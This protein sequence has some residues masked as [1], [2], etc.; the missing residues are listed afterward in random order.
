M[1]ERNAADTA[2]R[3]LA[4][5]AAMMA[6]PGIIGLF[7]RIPALIKPNA[8]FAPARPG[9]LVLVLTA[10]CTVLAL[11]A[12][13]FR[14]VRIL[15]VITIFMCGVGLYAN[16]ARIS[17]PL[18]RLMQARVPE[19]GPLRPGFGNALS[20]VALFIAIAVTSI[21]SIATNPSQRRAIVISALSSIICTIAGV[22]TFAELAGLLQAISAREWLQAPLQSLIAAGLLG[23]A[24]FKRVLRGERL[25]IA[26]P[27]WT[28]PVVGLGS[29]IVVVVLWSGLE[30]R[31]RTQLDA[32]ARIASGATHRAIDRQFTWIS[33]AT[34][35]MALFITTATSA[36]DL[37]G[38]S[39]TQLVSET[40]GLARMMLI[41]SAGRIIRST[42]ADSGDAISPQLMAQIR[43]LLAGNAHATATKM[44]PRTTA[45]SAGTRAESELSEQ[46]PQTVVGLTD[47][48]TGIAILEPIRS[49]L[50][51]S[52]VVVALIN[53]RELVTPFTT[54]TSSG[55][56]MHALV[57]DSLLV[58]PSPRPASPT[59]I[60]PM[61][62]GSRTIKLMVT[63]LQSAPSS[64]PDL[65][66]MLGLAIAAMLVL[67]LWLARKTYERASTVG[68]SRMQRAIERA[69]DGVWELDLLEGR[70][71]RSEA[72]LHYLGL[73]AAMANGDATMWISRIHP[74]DSATVTQA[75]EQHLSGRTD[76]FECEYRI[77]AGDETWHTIV[78][79]GRVIERA[80]DHRPLRLL[81]ISADITERAR[82]DAAREESDRRFR[83]MFDTAFQLQILLDLDGSILE[84][85]RAAAALAGSDVES[86]QGR[87]FS[88]LDWWPQDAL[89]RSRVQ[90]R[91]ERAHRGE[92]S[93]FEIELHG[94]GAR[95]AIVDFSLKPILDHEQQVVQV[96]AEG[97]DLTERKR[98]EASLREIGALTTM[99]QLAARVAHEINNP[100]AGIQNAFLLVRSAIST[101]HPHYRFVGAIEREIARIA[102]VTRQLYE[103]YRPDQ[104]MG[105]GSSVILAISDAVIFLE[106]VNRARQVRIVTDVTRAPSL[107]P[108]PDALLRQTLYNLVQNALDAS[109]VG[110][111]ITVTATADAAWCTIR[112]T[113]EGP[114]VPEA[115]RHRIFD[116]FFSTKDRSVKTSGMGIGLSLVR[117]SVLAV[118]GDIEVRDRPGGGTEFEVRLPMTPIDTGVLR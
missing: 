2:T 75:L 118:G 83:A 4:I 76:A 97:R 92:S 104:P 17:L 65:V 67:I 29:A 32:R 108:V 99:G 106:Q 26:P 35:R 11:S 72:L 98:A 25:A 96:L 16:V 40:D 95:S 93:R 45:P 6:M 58:G 41:D 102:A 103:T 87:M 59:L 79:R 69:T 51:G 56:L 60:T 88:S 105:T 101:D 112:V 107:V 39:V 63:A 110:G 8:A 90:E 44:S 73:D 5:A 47:S 52:A 80:R 61:A 68:M 23:A 66:L 91:F 48:P 116:P 34:N 71:Y 64:L 42:P 84:A 81:G 74:D 24:L 114:G 14:L 38:N 9:S 10:S 89:T 82:A 94:A 19:A 109:P 3:W 30:R 49:R 57:G 115:L 7:I 27:R 31:E 55:F 33:S 21:L 70:A 20:T 85:N 22:L 111:T 100:L 62:Y 53:E 28:L 12:R 18:D 113:D 1:V 43:A 13:R 77:R 50:F 54:D 78:D 46:L 37:F 36:S 117:Q 15:G 86:L